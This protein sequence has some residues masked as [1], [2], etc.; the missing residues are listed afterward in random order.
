M[1]LEVY[2]TG[3]EILNKNSRK[4]SNFAFHLENIKYLDQDWRFL[5]TIPK[6][7]SGKHYYEREDKSGWWM[8][9][10]QV[11]IRSYIGIYLSILG[12]KPGMKLFFIDLMSSFGLNC[13]TKN[14]G[15]DRFIFPGTSLNAALISNR[16]EKGFDGYY[17]NDSNFLQREVLNKRLH[18]LSEH[19][20]RPLDINI[21]LENKKIDSNQWVIET[22]KQ[23]KKKEKYYNYLMII[24]NEG[25]NISYNTLRKIRELH[26]YGDIVIT[27]QDAGI[28]RNIHN[29]QRIGEFFGN[30]ISVKT[31]RSELCDIYIEQLRKIGLGNIEKMKVA[32]ANQFYYTLL[33]CCR[34]NVSGDWLRL[35][36]FYN[37]ERFKNFTDKDL[38]R[39][40]DIK[41]GKQLSIDKYR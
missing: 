11:A 32:S 20:D 4:K 34:D 19:F 17:I 16:E 26:E 40:W 23:L 21:S 30:D 1:N 9:I 27:F 7:P 22:L 38:K 18:A 35:I 6:F 15:R 28:A 25:M 33:F 41:R 29:T 3:T 24:D 39:M 2:R 31:K 8:A 12:K 37:E 14:Q 36:K 13:V 10:K 5:R